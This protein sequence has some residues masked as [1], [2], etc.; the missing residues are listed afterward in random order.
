MNRWLVRSAAALLGVAGLFLSVGQSSAHVVFG[1]SLFSD[2]SIVDP[3]TG[4]AGVGSTFSN[5]NRTVRSNAGWV[6]GLDAT[7]GGDSHN[8][9]FMY[10]N[11]AGA[12][13]ID[14]TINATANSN[15]ASLLNPGY[16]LFSGAVPNVSHDGGYYP[17]KTT[18]ASWSPFA[19]ENADILAQPDNGGI[20]ERWGDFRANADVT[21]RADDSGGNPIVSTMT[22]TGLFGANSNA[23]SISG[24]YTLGPGL[25]TLVVGGVNSTDLAV[26]LSHAIATNGDYT[27]PSGA[28]TGY[29]NARLARNFNIQFN[30][31]PVPLPAAVWLFGS[32][33]A[34]IIAFARRRKSV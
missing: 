18:F 33:V 23:N 6:A 29:N 2:A 7:T 11:L 17:G 24:Q 25:Y 30:V 27:T 26:L 16:S 28:L 22:Y 10:F 5:Q 9:R 21:M 31:A 3:I 19:A 32:G 34:G 20:G 12:A 1:N 14:F 4:V 13:T 8:A 15:G